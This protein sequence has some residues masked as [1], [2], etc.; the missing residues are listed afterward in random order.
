M[1]FIESDHSPFEPL[2][3]FPNVSTQECHPKILP[4]PCLELDGDDL[5]SDLPCLDQTPH[6]LLHTF[7]ENHITTPLVISTLSPLLLPPLAHGSIQTPPQ[8]LDDLSEV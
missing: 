6:L 3:T 1:P 7:F 2:A 4:H 8:S 5:I